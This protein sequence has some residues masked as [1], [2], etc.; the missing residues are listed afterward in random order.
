MGHEL[1]R[2]KEL[3]RG[4]VGQLYSRGNDWLLSGNI[5]KGTLQN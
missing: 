5:Q 1:L 3:A 4:F 2:G